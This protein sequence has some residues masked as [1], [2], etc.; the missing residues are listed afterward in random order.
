MKKICVVGVDLGASGGKMARGLYDGHNVYLENYIDFPNEPVVLNQNLY[1]NIFSLYDYILKGLSKYA[2]YSDVMSL[3]VDSWGASY[4]FLDNKKRLLEM[5]YHYR[6]LRTENSLK[7][8]YNIVSKENIFK[9]TGCQPNR[10][11]TLPQLYSYIEN[12][13]SILSLVDTMLFLP[14]LIEYFLSG[15]ISTERS[16]AGTSSM[17]DIEQANWSFALLKQLNIPTKILTKIISPGTV[18]GEMLDDV[19]RSTG[20]KNTKIISVVGHDTA[21]AVVGIPRFGINQVYIS[22]GTNINMGVELVDSLV[23]D[24]VYIGG[25]KN[26][27]IIEDRKMLYRDFSAFWLLNEL[28]RTCYEEGNNYSYQDMMEMADNCPSPRV[29]IN[30][31][32][33]ELNNAGGN[34]KVKIN[35]YLISSNQRTL[36]TDSEF[37]RCILE[38]IALKVK[39]CVE[40][41]EKSIGI[42][43]D[44]ISIVNGGTKNYVLMQLICDALGKNIF[45]GLPHATILG[46]VLT[47]LYALNELKNLEEM[48]EV[49]KVSFVMKEYEPIKDNCERWDEDMSKIY[50]QTN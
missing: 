11:Y 38:S 42:P 35:D 1:W 39:W 23:N 45:A 30:V 46:N 6:D 18:R 5:I 25:F 16:I 26:A 36:E 27:S 31:E 49:S 44:R 4:G 10:S 8:M 22:I 50:K 40:Y 17:L 14:D 29:Y 19:S 21:S 24:Q 12:K 9:L 28:K 33:I 13:E 43:I 7:N 37:I 41:I 32:D 47:Q 20:L 15:D 2:T 3:G 34:M 48:R